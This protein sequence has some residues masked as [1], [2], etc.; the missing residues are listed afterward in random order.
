MGK[1]PYTQ[2]PSR[3]KPTPK[4]AEILKQQVATDGSSTTNSSAPCTMSYACIVTPFA[5]MLMLAYYAQIYASII[6]MWVYIW[7]IYGQWRVAILLWLLEGLEA[8]VV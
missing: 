3:R 4:V 5:Q 2:K 6:Y 8:P 7:I 1:A